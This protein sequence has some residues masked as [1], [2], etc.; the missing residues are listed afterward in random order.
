VVIANSDEKANT[1]ATLNDVNMSQKLT[2]TYSEIAKS[3]L[4]LQQ[5]AEKLELNVSGKDLSRNVTVKPVDD[6]SIL[7]ITVKDLNAEQAAKIANE[8]AKIFTKEITQIYKLDN[9]SQLSIATTPESPSNNTLTRDLILAVAVA[10]FGVAGIAFLRFYLDD[11]AKCSDDI[12]KTI[13]LPVTGKISKNDVKKGETELVA[14]KYPKAI[15]SENIKSLRTN[16]QFTAVDNKNLKTI[17]VTSTN[18]GEGKSFVSSNLAISFAQADKKVLLV[19]CDLRKGRVH[20]LFDIPNTDGLS[21][22][23]ADD[24]RDYEKY[25]RPTKVENLS[26]ITCG[27]YPPNPS[28]LLASQKN[29]RLINNLK[30]HYDTIIFDGAPIGGLADSVILS[31]FMDETLIVTKDGGTAKNDLLATKDA[32]S[33]VGAKVA[34]IVFNMVNQKATK[35][36]YYYSDKK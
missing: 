35:N 29:K 13:G 5:V 27:T 15:V 32:L 14:E 26:V 24:L 8:I 20:R 34:G 22:L 36:Y 6:T 30:H 12:E 10:I 17:L 2:T 16:L 1:A 21:N 28:E 3:E 9:V 4:V 33:K 25:V 11:S 18:A 31:S 7:S 23:L 19:D